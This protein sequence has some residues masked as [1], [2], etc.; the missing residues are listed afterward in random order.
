MSMRQKIKSAF[1]LGSTSVVA[2]AICKSLANRGCERFHLIA[3]DTASN[4][5]L[6]NELRTIYGASVTT[7]NRLSRLL[8]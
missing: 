2:K 5:L 6:A 8:G 7:K 4:N 1:I 3:R